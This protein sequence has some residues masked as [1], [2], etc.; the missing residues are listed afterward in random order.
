MTDLDFLKEITSLYSGSGSENELVCF[1]EKEF[2]ALG[3][4]TEKTG[5]N[6]LIV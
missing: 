6:S 2:S 3:F 1:L 5:L 4:K